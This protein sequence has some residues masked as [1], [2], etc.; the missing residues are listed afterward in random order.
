MQ[1]NDT[2]SME[3]G[4]NSMIAVDDRGARFIHI[5]WIADTNFSL[6]VVQYRQRNT[7]I[8]SNSLEVRDP[9]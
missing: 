5:T 1:C 9:T 7:R 4:W 3:D 6:Y 2:C 8:Y